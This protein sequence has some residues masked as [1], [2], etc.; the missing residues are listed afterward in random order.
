MS[1]NIEIDEYFE[2][3]CKGCNENL[4]ADCSDGEITV[5]PCKC[6]PRD[7]LKHT[8]FEEVNRIIRKLENQVSESGQ[9]RAVLNTIREEIETYNIINK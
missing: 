2:I 9:A 7:S 6:T 8:L 5:E 1:I 4:A 3:T